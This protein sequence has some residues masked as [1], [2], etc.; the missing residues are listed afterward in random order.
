MSLFRMVSLMPQCRK[1]SKRAIAGGVVAIGIAIMP[2][3]GAWSQTSGPAEIGQAA[4]TL[5][6]VETAPPGGL[7]IL[8]KLGEQM[9]GLNETIGVMAKQLE[10]KS[11]EIKSL[12]AQ[13]EK[14]RAESKQKADLV[15]ELQDNLI[16]ASGSLEAV[17]KDL[18][19]SRREIDQLSAEIDAEKSNSEA[20]TTLKSDIETLTEKNTSLEAKAADATASLETV[21]ADLKASTDRLT[22]LQVERDALARQRFWLSILVA[23]AL[24]GVAYFAM[25]G[26]QTG[27]GASKP[28][29]ASTETDEPNASVAPVT[30]A[31]PATKTNPSKSASK[32]S[33]TKVKPD[34]AATDN[35]TP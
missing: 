2:I 4:S 9:S 14:A 16:T 20:I 30:K 15:N 18:A 22:Q 31:K 26:R 11:N 23:L 24:I 10:E 34:K 21:Q 13:L 3:T 35:K 28:V 33:N 29:D 32:V 27:D 6:S 5:P 7:P 1:G 12:Q 19:S 8:N 25:R 17:Q